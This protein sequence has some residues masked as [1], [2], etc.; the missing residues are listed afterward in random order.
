VIVVIP[1]ETT[2]SAFPVKQP[3]NADAPD[4]AIDSATISRARLGDAAAF[5]RIVEAYYPRCLRFARAMRRSPADAEDSVQEAFVRV[6]RALPRYEE[7]QRFESWLFH[8]LANC[9]R[10]ANKVE[11][12]HD[13]ESLH[14]TDLDRRLPASERTD[15][16][17]DREFGAEVRRALAELPAYNREVF[18]LHYVEEFSYEEIQR[19]TGVKRSALKMRVKRASDF[20][21][22]RLAGAPHD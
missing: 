3:N 14:E 11:R 9:C 4:A 13:A 18:L 22:A 21:R 10:T 20:L 19:I 6:F 1:T 12:R 2:L 17:M 5:T 8:I 16:W 15:G 7:R